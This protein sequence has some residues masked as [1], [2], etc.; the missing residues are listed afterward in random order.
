MLM[1][2]MYFGSVAYVYL[3]NLCYVMLCYVM[4][5]YVMLCYN[6][7]KLARSI[8]IFSTNIDLVWKNYDENII[9][10]DTGNLK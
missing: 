6:H 10:S 7:S 8:I 3:I 1:Y 5:C 4:L 9:M 2:T